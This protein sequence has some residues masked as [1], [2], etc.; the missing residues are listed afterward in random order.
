MATTTKL[1]WG[2]LGPGGI[3]K[4]FQGGVAHSETSE[5]VALGT[6]TP[7]RPGLAENFPGARILTGYEALL[8]D[9]EVDAVYIAILHPGHAEWAIKAAEAGKHVLVEKPAGINAA[10]FETMV[11]AARKAGTFLG[12]AFMYRCH[13]QT[14]RI[15]D[16]VANGAV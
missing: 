11:A 13:P 7:D 4:A 16:L 1:R 5:I 15:V 10:Q 2:I 9:P 8:A 6:R 12:E 3:A 14:A